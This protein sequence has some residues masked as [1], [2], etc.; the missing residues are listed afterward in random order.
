MK[1]ILK[2]VI[3][4][5]LVAYLV[6]AFFTFPFQGSKEVCQ[7]VNV[8]IVDSAKAGFITQAEVYKMLQKRH[9]VGM[10]MDSIHGTEIESL[11]QQNSFIKEA[12]CYKSPGG[13]VNIM[14]TQRLPLLRVMADNGQDYYI[15][16]TGRTMNPQG[17][18]ANLIVATGNI[19]KKYAETTLRMIGQTLT[20][21]DFWNS[22]VEQIQI[23]QN[24]DIV[25]VPRLG[26][27]VILMG[28]S[29][30]FNKKL[31]NLMSFYKN[32]MPQVGWNK[33]SRINAEHTNQIICTKAKG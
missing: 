6:Y 4:I 30:D 28:D 24:G 23:E 27:H 21:K 20:E 3:C 17:Y 15:D 5:A 31:R 11:L 18:S 9:I 33:Y 12:V 7:T 32:V 2:L 22:F 19:N 13:R 26:N 16:V 1:I 8:C 14:V 29:T 25:L 10:L